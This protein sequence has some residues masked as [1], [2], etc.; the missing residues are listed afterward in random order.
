MSLTAGKNLGEKRDMYETFEEKRQ[1]KSL[2]K[3]EKK[4]REEEHP[5]MRRR[6]CLAPILGSNLMKA[7]AAAPCSPSRDAFLST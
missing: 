2:I 1:R 5:C 7:A 3:Q 4:V 6:V